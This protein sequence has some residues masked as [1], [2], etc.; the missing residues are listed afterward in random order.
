MVLSI[1]QDKLPEPDT[2]EIVGEDANSQ[3]QQVMKNLA[4]V[5]RACA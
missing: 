4:E 1:V 2:M 5:L 3:A